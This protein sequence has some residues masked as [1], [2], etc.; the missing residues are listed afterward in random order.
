M[1]TNEQILA[2]AEQA[3]FKRTYP[4]CGIKSKTCQGD[5]WEGN[6]QGLVAAIRAAALEE[7]AQDRG[8]LEQTNDRLCERL[9]MALNHMTREQRDAFEAE[10]SQ[11]M[12]NL[13][14]SDGSSKENP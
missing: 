3:G 12:A 9:V 2:L 11:F 5:V 8:A 4:C 1:M 6:I 13:K 14:Q 7:A 10:W